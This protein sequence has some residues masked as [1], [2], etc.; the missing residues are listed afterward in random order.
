MG[1]F[2]PTSDKNL[3]LQMSEVGLQMG[4]EKS[5]TFKRIEEIREYSELVGYAY[6]YIVQR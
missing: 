3:D 4:G 5:E 1:V 6:T 2:F